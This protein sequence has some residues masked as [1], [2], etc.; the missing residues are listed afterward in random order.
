MLDA[1][2]ADFHS[3][4]PLIVYRLKF[5]SA[6]VDAGN[7]PLTTDQRGAPRPVDQAAVTNAAG[8]N[9]SDIGAYEMR[10]PTTFVVTNTADSGAG[11]LRQAIVDAND[12]GQFDT[13]TFNIPTSDP[14]W[15]S[16]LDLMGVFR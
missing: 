16:G 1:Q 4:G 6:A 11:S 14:G 12:E 13:I 5:S 15:T 3:F 8:G 9:G 7:S 2:L 10:G